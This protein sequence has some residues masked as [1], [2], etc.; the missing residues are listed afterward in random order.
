[1]SWRTV[2]ALAIAIVFCVM[3][4]VSIHRPSALAGRTSLPLLEQ[5]NASQP[6]R[7]MAKVSASSQQTAVMLNSRQLPDGGEAD[8]VAPDVVIR[9]QKRAVNFP[10]HVAKTL[11]SHSV[12]AQLLPPKNTTSKPGVRNADVLA[13]DTVVQYGPDVKMWSGNPKRVGLDRLVH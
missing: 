1:M 5:Q 2:E 6:A 7:P 13:A 11:T 4:G 12:Q 3:M 10:G 9:Y 8:I